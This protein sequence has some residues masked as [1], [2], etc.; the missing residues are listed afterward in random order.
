M[1]DPSGRLGLPQDRPH[2]DPAAP[3]L[4]ALL[5]YTPGYLRGRLRQGAQGGC[6]ARLR[7]RRISRWLS[8]DQGGHTRWS[9]RKG[10]GV[11]HYTLG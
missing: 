8:P 1:P 11:T 10:G 9:V 5:V 3:D 7:T 6:L 2:H 4:H